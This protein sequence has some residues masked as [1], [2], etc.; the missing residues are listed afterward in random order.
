MEQEENRI[1][2]QQESQ[3][4]KITNNNTD[5]PTRKQQNINNCKKIMEILDDRF[6]EEKTELLFPI[7]VEKVQTGEWDHQTIAHNKS[8]NKPKF[9]KHHINITLPKIGEVSSVYYDIMT[10]GKQAWN[11]YVTTKK[12]ADQI[13]PQI[14]ECTKNNQIKKAKKLFKQWLQ[15]SE[16][17]QKYLDRCKS[18]K[19]TE[20]TIKDIKERPN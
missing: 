6:Y 18:K 5:S 19:K 1:P 11:M 20:E 15:L 14:V 3:G 7:F 10:S 16:T 12:Q 13:L 9:G 4:E 2:S 8:V 17:S